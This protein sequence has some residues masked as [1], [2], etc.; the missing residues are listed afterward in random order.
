VK[1]ALLRFLLILCAVLS[2][3]SEHEKVVVVNVLLVG[4]GTAY[5][6]ISPRFIELG[7]GDLR[8]HSGLPVIAQA[9]FVRADDMQRF[10]EKVRPVDIVVC[11][12]S[13]QL[14]GLPLLKAESTKAANVCGKAA[15]CPAVMA[16]WVEPQKREAVEQ[17][18][19]EL[20]RQ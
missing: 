9:I 4:N 8:T 6:A 19:R 13:E 18:F 10:V 3:C 16:P 11:D 15:N 20:T 1:P 5:Q 14:G 7:K 2:G 17:V 12:S